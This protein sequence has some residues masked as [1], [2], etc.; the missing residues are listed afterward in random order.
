MKMNIEFDWPLF[1]YLSDWIREQAL[2]YRPVPPFS[3]VNQC[4]YTPP[5]PMKPV[6][7]GS[8]LPAGFVPTQTHL[9][10][11]PATYPDW[12]WRIVC[13]WLISHC[14]CLCGLSV[15]DI[16]SV[17]SSIVGRKHP[18]P[19]QSRQLK[20]SLPM[21]A[22]VLH[23][24][25]SQVCVCVRS[26]YIYLF[27]SY[28]GLLSPQGWDNLRGKKKHCGDLPCGAIDNNFFHKLFSVQ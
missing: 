3:F 28:F 12:S 24:L 14:F 18:S 20:Q 1:N 9:L 25:T 11:S 23:L 22:V 27:A 10:T 4:R 17:L 21:M 5:L 26:C 2:R 6:Q 19:T 15:D 7:T 16:L 13:D 8:V